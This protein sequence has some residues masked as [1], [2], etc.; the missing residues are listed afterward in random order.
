MI[1]IK[2][3]N[4]PKNCLECPFIDDSMYYCGIFH[5][6]LVPDTFA[7]N[8]EVIENNFRVLASGRNNDCPLIEIKE[9]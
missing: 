1:A 5:I 3:M 2:E 6:K 8:Y 7:L 9:R 4:M